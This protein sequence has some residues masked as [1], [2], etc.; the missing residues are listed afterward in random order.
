[1]A[2]LESILQYLEDNTQIRLNDGAVVWTIND[3]LENAWQE[4]EDYELLADGIYLV[5]IGD[6]LERSPVF[7]F[8]DIE[9]NPLAIHPDGISLK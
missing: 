1:M 6:Q 2:T 9:G 4:K 8:E 5:N 3:L 7:A